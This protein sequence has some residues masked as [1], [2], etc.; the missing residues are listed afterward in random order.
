M[1]RSIRTRVAVAAM[2]ACAALT[3]CGG[4]TTTAATAPSGTLRVA[5]TDAPACGFDQVIV[6]VER[7]RVHP[8][9]G[10]NDTDSGWIDMA[11]NPAKQVNLLD[12]QNAALIDL[13]QT[14]LPAG[15]YTQMRLILSANTAGIA[16]NYV[17]PTGA[18]MQPVAMDTPSAQR[19]GVKLIHGFTVEPNKTTSLV[20]DFDACRSIVQRGD[21]SYGLKPVIGVMPMTL[22]KIAGYVQPALAGVTVTAQKG[23]V[24]FRATQPDASGH[25]VLGPIDPA[26]PYDVVFTGK[27][28]TTAVIAAVPVTLDQTT[29]VNTIGSAVTMPASPSGSVSGAMAPAA[30]AATGVVRALQTVG[31]VSAVEVAQVNTNATTGAYAMP[32][33]TAAP[34][35][36]TYAAPLPPALNFQPQTTAGRYRLEA[37]AT[38]F[39]KQTGSEIV[40]PGGGSLPAQNFTLAP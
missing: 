14:A 36:V 7:V 5:L 19:S 33:P 18:A 16:A 10:A 39:Q 31:S 2:A 24:V 12:L 29:N 38:G 21:G 20:L 8:S 22:T 40:V 13:G 28:M 34:R 11:V 25:F 27:D 3:A 35:L 9:M 1:T 37:A 17:V 23:G 4:G 26:G 30:A 15:Q 6:T 32:L